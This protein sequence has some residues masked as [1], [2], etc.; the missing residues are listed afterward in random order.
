MKKETAIKL[1]GDVVKPIRKDLITW[2]DILAQYK[3]SYKKKDK[4]ITISICQHKGGVGKTTTT[5]N[6]GYLFSC[7]GKT[8]LIDLDPQ[9]DLSQACNILIKDE[10]SLKEFIDTKNSEA[11]YSIDS[12]LDIIPNVKDFENWKK[13]LITKRNPSY[14]LS[15]S[16]K[17]IKEHYD[18]I[19][20]DCPPS[21][22]ISFDLAFYSSNFA[23]II[24]DGH[25]FAMQGL[26]NIL[27]EIKKIKDD[28]V[29]G[30]LNLEILGI[31]FNSYKNA[32]LLNAI[33]DE[34]KENYP[35]FNTKIRENIAIPE[36]QLMK[37]NVFN[38]DET[39]HGSIDFFNLFLEIMEK[40]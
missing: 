19:L 38:Y 5:Q 31:V 13:E 35:I 1:I 34:A 36:S 23:L 12:N 37:S 17:T 10:P 2:Q 11:I 9:A 39:C 26:E 40:I 6:L 8:L 33:I 27:V 15:K 20:I 30:E 24:S 28:D 14:L 21:M 7:L 32:N 18:F 3:R 4:N 25:P 29:S 16:L 22:D